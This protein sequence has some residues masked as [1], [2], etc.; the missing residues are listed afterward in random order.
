[1]RRLRGDIVRGKTIGD[2]TTLEDYSVLASHP[3]RRFFRAAIKMPSP[4]CSGG[5]RHENP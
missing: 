4:T 2:T 5:R 1:M 3:A